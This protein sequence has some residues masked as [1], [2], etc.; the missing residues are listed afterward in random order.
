MEPSDSYLVVERMIRRGEI[1]IEEL[2]DLLATLESQE[3]ITVDQHIALLELAA[4]TDADRA[5]PG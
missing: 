1:T 5:S 4:K 3:L 2:Q